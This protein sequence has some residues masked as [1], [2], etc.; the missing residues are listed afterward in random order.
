MR[1]LAEP[2]KKYFLECGVGTHKFVGLCAAE[3]S[4]T[5]PQRPY[6]GNATILN[7]K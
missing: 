3:Q 4:C 2:E 1:F 6:T 5:R 7:D